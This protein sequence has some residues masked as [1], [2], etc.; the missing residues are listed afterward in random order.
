MS[1]LL[2][3]DIFPRSFM[4]NTFLRFIYF[5]MVSLT[6]KQNIY[7]IISVTYLLLCFSFTF[8]PYIRNLLVFSFISFF[9]LTTFVSF[10]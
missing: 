2:N 10:L 6:M 8:V 5:I 9:S 7:Y 3:D 1:F 4:V